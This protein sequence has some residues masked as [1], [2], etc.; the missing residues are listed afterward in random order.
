MQT[1]NPEFQAAQIRGKLLILTYSC[2]S[3]KVNTSTAKVDLVAIQF[4]LSSMTISQEWVN[5]SR[6]VLG[7]YLSRNL[8]CT[9]WYLGSISMLLCQYV[10]N[11][12]RVRL[13]PFTVHF[14]MKV[15]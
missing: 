1:L 9:S 6:R 8:D 7:E 13:L 4:Y 10:K 5:Y 11:G 2:V 15:Y 12:T 3:K 14:W